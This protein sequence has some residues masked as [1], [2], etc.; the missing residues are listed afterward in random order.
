MRGITDEQRDKLFGLRFTPGIDHIVMTNDPGFEFSGGWIELTTCEDLKAGCRKAIRLSCEDELKNVIE[1]TEPEI[2]EFQD[3]MAAEM[4]TGGQLGVCS[5]EEASIPAHA[6][7]KEFISKEAIPNF[8]RWG[9]EHCLKFRRLELRQEEGEPM[10]IHALTVYDS[11]E[12][13]VKK[14]KRCFKCHETLTEVRD[15]IRDKPYYFCETS[16]CRNF[17]LLLDLY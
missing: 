1:P 7:A 4:R 13:M 2:R 12:G 3:K 9:R 17:R 5:E 10:K 8:I 16:G 11:G 15:N 6:L 14:Y